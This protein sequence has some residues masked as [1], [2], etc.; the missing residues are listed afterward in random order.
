M[1]TS[2]VLVSAEVPVSAEPSVETK[3]ADTDASI[4]TEET[5]TV[6]TEEATIIAPDEA[7]TIAP[8]EASYVPPDAD[9]DRVPADAMEVDTE[10][11]PPDEPVMVTTE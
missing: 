1:A 9:S 11:N 2:E 6:P 4:P 3:V 8:E 5:S 10:T 7:T